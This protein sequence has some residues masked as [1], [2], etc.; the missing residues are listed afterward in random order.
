MNYLQNNNDEDFGFQPFEVEN[1]SSEPLEN[2]GF[3]PFEEKSQFQKDKELIEEDL[4]PEIE[5]HIARLTSRG[6]EQ[7][8]G[9]PGN[10]RDLSYLAKDYFEKN[11]PNFLKQI[12]EPV[13]FKKFEEAIPVMKTVSDL[14][15]YLPTSSQVKKFSEEKSLGYTSPKNEY[16]RVGDEVFEKIVSSSLPGTGQRNVWKNIA[17]PIVSSLGKETVKYLG[18]GEKGQLLTELGLSL[19]IPLAAGNAPELNRNVWRDI[20]RNT[21]NVSVNAN[22]GRQ[23]AQDLITR[24]ETQALGSAGENRVINTLRN[25]LGNTQN[26]QMSA[27]QLVGFNRSLNEIRGDPALLTGSRTLLNEVSHII[28][29]TG[30]QFEHTAPDF[31]RNWQRANEI[32][33]AIQQ[34]NYVARTVERMSDRIISEGARSLFA[35][36]LH[37]GAA[38]AATVP[39]MFAIYKMTQV[40]DRMGRSPELMRYY[41]GVLTNSIR[42]NTALAAKNLSKL[43]NA[44]LKD[45]KKEKPPFKN[46]SQKK[47]TSST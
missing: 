25:F 41:T 26:G 23:R 35:G 44:L 16:E 18:A 15:G 36:A 47:K 11:K 28:R 30:R 40:M 46:P 38:G 39:P 45:E 29:D 42:G 20:E 14:I 32:H 10:L 43:D 4:D 21:P 1:E 6:L 37:A 19:A 7:A 12:P 5:R 27:R 8:V 2:F 22:I 3:K 24:L 17:A 13:A 34:S 9:L 31:Y 33:G